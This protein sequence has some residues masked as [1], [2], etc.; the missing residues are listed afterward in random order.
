VNAPQSPAAGA[1][2]T[3]EEM[4]GAR[5]INGRL[6]GLKEVYDYKSRYEEE[7]HPDNLQSIF[8]TQLKHS[9]PQI[10]HPD[11]TTLIPIYHLI[12]LIQRI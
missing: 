3:G 8:F 2:K 11:F 5:G 10:I 12:L 6:T 1:V 9:P 4:Y 7:H